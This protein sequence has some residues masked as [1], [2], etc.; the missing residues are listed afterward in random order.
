MAQSAPWNSE[1]HTHCPWSQKPFTHMGS[2]SSGVI[3]DT[4]ADG[5]GAGDSAGGGTEHAGPRNP[6]WH[7]HPAAVHVPCPLQASGQALSSQASEG[8]LVH[9]WSQWHS[10]PSE[11]PTAA[12]HTPC[13]LHTDPSSP[14]PHNGKSQPMPPQPRSH[15]Q[16][17]GLVKTQRPCPPQ[18]P[19][20]QGLAVRAE[21]SSPVNPSK[22]TQ[23]VVG[24]V[25]HTPLPLQ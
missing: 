6:N 12:K 17:G 3:S 20:H 2:Q 14:T 5:D 9:P 7:S 13:E 16:D 19:G 8:P 15:S 1:S 10:K 21:Q 24:L 18:N 11:G 22:Q 25:T 4:E 23:C